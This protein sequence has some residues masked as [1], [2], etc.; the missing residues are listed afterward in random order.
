MTDFPSADNPADESWYDPEYDQELIE[1][2]IAKQYHIL[3]SEQGELKYRDWALLVSG[4]MDDTPLGRVV[5]V[6]SESNPDRIKAFGQ[7]ERRIR[8]EWAAYRSLQKSPLPAEESKA[9]IAALETMIAGM[10]GGR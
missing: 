9:Q 1:Q 8:A 7:S 3:P 10:F 4:L 2:S 5:L 6:R